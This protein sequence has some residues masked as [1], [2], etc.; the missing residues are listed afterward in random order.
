MVHFW[1]FNS[2]PLIYLPVS[3]TIP[4]DFV[5]VLFCFY[6]CCFVVYLE[7]RESIVLLRRGKKIISRNRGSKG[8]GREK[9]RGGKRA[10]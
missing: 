1:V 6:H 8:S 10:G 5:L 2:I 9:G 7:V 4:W 3:V